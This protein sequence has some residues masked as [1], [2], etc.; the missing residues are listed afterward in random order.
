M[1]RKQTRKPS[2]HGANLGFEAIFAVAIREAL[3]SKLMC[4]GAAG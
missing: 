2:R 4:G 3:L 1:A